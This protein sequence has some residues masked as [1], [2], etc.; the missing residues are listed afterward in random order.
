M[1]AEILRSKASEVEGRKASVRLAEVE[2]R[3]R[4]AVAT[5]GFRAALAGVEIGIIA[6]VKRR[7]PSAGDLGGDRVLTTIARAYE[8]G[9]A[10]ALSVLTDA[11]YFGGLD[12]DLAACRAATEL[13][14]L[15]KDF[16]IDPYQIA[17]SRALGADAVLLI[18]RA[19]PDPLL[20]DL[21]ALA[22]EWGLDALVEVH[23]E[24]DLERALALPNP[25]VGIN[26]RDLDTM[27]TD[28]EVTERLTAQVPPWVT[29]VSESGIETRRDIERLGESGVRAFLIGASLLRSGD[30]TKKLKELRGFLE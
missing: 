7:S 9:G 26:N 14:V 17:E 8:S 19:L 10:C 18:V 15:R 12:G 16:I 24:K 30:P 22:G 20:G 21:A 2:A 13:P 29:V 27:T 25:I 28:L 23:D 3:A 11:H 6:E 1:L 5:R 4:D